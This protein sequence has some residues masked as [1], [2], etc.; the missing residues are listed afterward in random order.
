MLLRPPLDPDR[1]LVIPRRRLGRLLGRLFHLLL[2]GDLSIAIPRLLCG[3][4][5]VVLSFGA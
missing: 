5:T 2:R 4:L 3:L 1:L